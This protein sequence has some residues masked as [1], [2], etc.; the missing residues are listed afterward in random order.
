VLPEDFAAGGLHHA[1]FA[2]PH[3]VVTA[4]EACIR[5]SVGRLCSEKLNDIRDRVCAVIRQ[6]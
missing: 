6:G 3:R 4:N 1:S 5:R 2:L